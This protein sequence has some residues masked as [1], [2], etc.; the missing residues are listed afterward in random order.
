[1]S[2]K[3][4]LLVTIFAGFSLGAC[5]SVKFPGFTE[6]DE[7]ASAPSQ[8]VPAP[9]DT[10]STIP[11]IKPIPEVPA[12]ETSLDEA[13]SSV[14]DGSPPA[15]GA[16][17]GVEDLSEF[18][19]IDNLLAIN[20]ARCAPSS[21]ETLTLA[22]MADADVV[23]AAVTPQ[24]VNGTEITTDSF[25]G[26]VKME[27]RRIL[28]SGSVSS[29]H[30]G[31]TRIANNWFV[32]ASHC[33]DDTYDEIRLIAT[34]SSLKD[35]R[36]LV[37]EANA[38]LC[39]SAY[40]GASGQYSNDVAL[41]GVSDETAAT[42]TDVPIARFGATDRALVPVN[43][44]NARMAG[45]GLTSF[46]RGELS[47][48]LLQADLRLVSS[49]P[50]AITV[51]STENSGPCIGDSGGPLLIDEAGGRSK[52][53]GVLS[54]VE[55]NRGTGKFCSGDYNARYTNLAGYLDWIETAIGVCSANPELCSR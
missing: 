53:I 16:A 51:S 52:V 29:G 7:T 40:G 19:G 30:C 28:A 36:A 38:T 15:D 21:E 55:Q 9:Q 44:P 48:T 31:A 27:P 54:V 24:A 17:T 25:P 18:A 10:A 26:I 23:A 20:A 6:T 12:T 37:F 34:E 8:T 50:A 5:D 11:A 2:F 39:H 41:I 42:L 1:M 47:N 49:G 33:L 46:D 32:T 13:D 43:Y 14:D 3:K 22:E 35:P 45:W 4:G